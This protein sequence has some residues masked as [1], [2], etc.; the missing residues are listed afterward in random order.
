MNYLS[1]GQYSVIAHITIYRG[2]GV[3]LIFGIVVIRLCGLVHGKYKF[4]PGTTP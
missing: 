4:A 1:N 3:P 2:V